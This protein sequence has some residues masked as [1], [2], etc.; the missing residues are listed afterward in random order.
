[1]VG[2]YGLIFEFM[3]PGMV[4]PGVVGTICLLLGLYALNML[5]INYAGLALML[6]GIT[7]LTIEAFN[8]T[9]VLGLGGIVAFVLGAVMLVRVETPGFRVSWSVIGTVVAMFAGLILVIL[10]SLQ[11]ARKGP[12]RVGAQAMPGLS[13]EVLD[14]SENEGH[15]FAQGE[16]WQA[17]GAETFKPGDVVE[18][19]NI[20]DLTLVVR[21]PPALTGEGGA[22]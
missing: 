3:S 5:P 20:T 8:P 16:R 22:S 12:V 17:R 7:L 11:R 2:V 15:V 6:V 19:A 21:R 4:A 1:M 18:V 9:V 13:A 14:W 10:G